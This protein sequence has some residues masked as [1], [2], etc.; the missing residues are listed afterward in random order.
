MYIYKCIDLW[1]YIYR[2]VYV[3][4]YDALSKLLFKLHKNESNTD[5]SLYQ[6]YM[7]KSWNTGD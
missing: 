3:Y 2:Q 6:N 7:K 4:M 1:V 5:F